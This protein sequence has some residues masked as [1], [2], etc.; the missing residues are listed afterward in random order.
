MSESKNA[1]FENFVLFAIVGALLVA[2]LLYGAYLVLPFVL[3][4]LVPFVVVS[5]VVGFVLRMAGNPSEGIR[6]ISRY[7]AVVMTYAGMLFIIGM[8]FFRNLERA[9]VVN[10]DGKLTGQV[11]VDWPKLNN[12]YNDWRVRV[13]ADAPFEG[14]RAKA[15]IGVVY[16][17]L[18]VGWIFLMSLF[19]GGPGFYYWLARR[20]EEEV[21]ETIE[22]IVLDRV[23]AKNQRLTEKEKNLDQIINKNKLQLEL[24]IQ[25]MEQAKE[26]LKAE[27]QSLR[28]KLEF[29]P[30]VPRPSENI[31]SN[32]KGVLDQDLF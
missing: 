12:W 27:N 6:G 20:D 26:E 30:E 5:L 4:Y 24:K 22:K 21:H 11:V 7:R 28:A 13:Y 25:K 16:D 17:R 8:V 3:F 14:L 31:E 2:G 1:H 9:K 10:K 15:Q 32:K 18:E 19:L 23:A 29:A